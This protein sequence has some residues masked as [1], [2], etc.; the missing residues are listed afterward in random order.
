M[1]FFRLAENLLS[2][3]R[4]EM[5]EDGLCVA[6]ADRLAWFSTDKHELVLG[7][8][9]STEGVDVGRRARLVHVRRRIVPL[10]FETLY[11][12]LAVY[13]AGLKLEGACHGGPVV[14]NLRW[15]QGTKCTRRLQQCVSVRRQETTV[16]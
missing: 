11:P 6:A 13:A 14:G 1:L 7:K 2:P 16:V 3:V 8:G 4:R 12:V 9:L 10:H 15:V 5:S